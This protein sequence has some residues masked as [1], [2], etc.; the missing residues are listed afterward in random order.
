MAV[1]RQWFF[2]LFECRV[3]GAGCRGKLPCGLYDVCGREVSGVMSPSSQPLQALLH[4]I[5]WDAEFAKGSFA[6]GYYDRVLDQEKVVSFAS[7]SMDP[8]AGGFSLHDEDGIF[9]HIPLHRV[10][11]VYKDGVVIWQRPDHPAAD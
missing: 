5:K 8:G 7:I 10:R 11:T 6:L 4:R 1:D 9:A 2:G 3:L